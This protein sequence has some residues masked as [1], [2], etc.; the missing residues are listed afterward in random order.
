[1]KNL[2]IAL[3]TIACLSL[4]GFQTEACSDPKDRIANVI[5]SAG[6]SSIFS[7][8]SSESNLP[9][10]IPEN[11][12]GVSKKLFPMKKVTGKTRDEAMK[13]AE[14]ALGKRGN[15]VVDFRM[16]SWDEKGVVAAL[17]WL[18]QEPNYNSE[19]IEYIILDKASVKNTPEISKRLAALSARD[20]MVIFLVY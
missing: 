20:V 2:K 8:L 9:A 14:L 3:L 17:D 15:G 13:K 6:G 5:A 12:A 16:K 4:A 11:Q 18:I 1:M 19:K 7:G 10:V